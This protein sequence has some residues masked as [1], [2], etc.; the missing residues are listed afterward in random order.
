MAV[1][2][3][4]YK[5]LVC[6]L[7]L[8]FVNY[9]LTAQQYPITYYT[10]DK[11]LA[12]NQVLAIFQDNKGYMWFSTSRGLF[13]YNGR[14]YKSIGKREGLKSNWQFDIIED[15]R[16]NIW[17]S[18]N[19][20]VDKITNG[21]V[22]NWIL[23]ES[24]DRFGIYI[25]K[26]ERIWVFSTVYPGDI[27]YFSKSSSGTDSLHNFSEKFNFKNQAVINIT[28]DQHGGVY[29][30]TRNGKLFRFFANE[31]K[32]IKIDELPSAGIT[33]AFFDSN[34]NFILCSTKGA[35][36]ISAKN[37]A[38]LT[39]GSSGSINW[40]IN[41]PVIFGLQSRKG[42]FWFATRG[43]GL[44]RV[45]PPSKNLS[46]NLSQA[47]II[48]ITEQN[49]LLS[50]VVFNL[51]EDYEGNI[52]IGHPTKGVSK[53][54]ALM[55]SNYGEKENL[56]A[57][58]V[59][60]VKQM[61]GEI[62]CS[63]ENGLFRFK[64]NKFEKVDPSGSH[65][66]QTIMCMLPLSGEIFQN[67]TL[68]L[69]SVNGLYTFNQ[70]SI[71][72][73]GLNKKVIRSL[74][75]DHSGKIWIGTHQGLFLMQDDLIIKEQDFNISNES[76]GKLFEVNNKDLFAGTEKGLFIIENGTLPFE[77]KKIITPDSAVTL[78]NGSILKE[79]INDIISDK[80]GN[81]LIA[82]R[83][84]LAVINKENELNNIIDLN[85]LDVVVLHIDKRKQLWAGTSSGL[86]LLNKNKTTDGYKVVAHY[87]NHEGLASNEF[88]VSGTIY[89]D[90]KGKIYLGS[91]EGLTILDPSEESISSITPKCYIAG[92]RTNDSTF[93]YLS[94][95]I[96]ELPQ[97]QS[98][99]SFLCE[100]LSFYKEDAI[101]Y[102]YYLYPVEEK[103]SN[104]TYNSVITYGYLEPDEYT[105][106][107]KAVNQFGIESEP[108]ALSFKILAPFWKQ[109]WFI[110]A[111]IIIL[112]F[113][114][115][116]VN[117]Y[118]QK[119]I[120]KRNLLLEK[121]VKE[122]TSEI[123]EKS[124]KLE[125]SKIQ[126]EQQY[127]QLV[128]A[129]KELVEKRELEKAHNEIQLLKDK[130]AKENIYLRERHGIIQEANS[131]IGRSKSI[132]EIRKMVE[133]IAKTDSTVLIT[134]NTG[135]GKNLVAEAIHDLS[136]RKD[137]ALI[138]VNCAAI[139]ESLVESELFGHEKGSF[140]G[141]T[142][143]REGKFEVADGSTI[144]L[145]EIGDMP[146]TVQAKVLNVLQSKTFT[147][148]GSNKQIKVNV[149]IIA[150]TN[151]NLENLVKEGKFRQDL[152]YRINVY[153]IHIPDLKERP[154]DIEPIAK[155]FIDRYSKVLNKKITAIT[156][157]ALN[158]LQSYSYPGNIRELE[159]IIHRAIIICKS[160][161]ISDEE[162]IIQASSPSMNSKLHFDWGSDN[163]KTLEEIERMYIKKV[164]ES[165]NGKISGSTGAAAILGLHPNTLRSRM[166]KLGISEKTKKG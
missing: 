35:G 166:E 7:L 33:Y 24:E 11:G 83:K 9:N 23:K 164:L 147:R 131:I 75:E 133:Q 26:Y 64:D 57:N 1:E 56:K 89:E 99:V 73:L 51:F 77:S 103:W 106:Y 78:F 128:E 100:G 2:L 17:V 40:I 162:I 160:D 130:L 115:Y 125:E 165:V 150:A 12:G 148:V 139:P 82:T 10:R 141:A 104:T 72:Y 136:S 129:Q 62:F 70:N 87:S 121:M 163:F 44:F 46:S 156:R 8:V 16:G 158:V 38:L 117:Q 138:T 29:F 20:G 105:F 96:I 116:G 90:S 61:N 49:G 92:L 126:I 36:Y 85:N 32:E 123:E 114:G 159:N 134:G 5:M 122:K 3:E 79:S 22:E 59:L 94:S 109:P 65:S 144:F 140:T 154:D 19:K 6:F 43:D 102:E 152:L 37:F 101:R 74:M 30:L 135:V 60:S 81:I 80:D 86:Y 149:R 153:T 34:N 55:F 63:T 45:S 28:E 50:N 41:S 48:N 71:K 4:N 84:G 13:K 95:A 97:H 145:D 27:F 118:R 14:E 25:D 143:K 67:K 21:K 108:Q 47:N 111:A 39:E 31:I 113:V 120:L 110:I 93:S 155:Y 151:H 161:I 68:L 124:I 91:Y 119:H 76:I 88:T 127:K 157:S 42:N 142:E 98:K 66:N 15:S 112:V 107:I 137:R 52:W 53:I 146:L 54:S 132:R 69:G 58:A 18:D